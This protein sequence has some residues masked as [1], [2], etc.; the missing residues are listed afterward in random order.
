[1]AEEK[2]LPKIRF[3]STD[4]VVFEVERD[5]IR[6]MEVINTMLTGTS[7]VFTVFLFRM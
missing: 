3:V 5:S 2:I 7:D 6:H 4:D 1:M